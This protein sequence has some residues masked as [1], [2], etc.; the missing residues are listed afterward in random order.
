V[1]VGPPGRGGGGLREGA[2]RPAGGAG[3][4][5]AHGARPGPRARGEPGSAAPDDQGAPDS[6]WLGDGP[7]CRAAACWKTEEHREAVRAFVEK[8]PP[9]FR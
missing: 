5:A 8:R 7:L 4:P 2:R 9:R 6:Q 1:P 3:G